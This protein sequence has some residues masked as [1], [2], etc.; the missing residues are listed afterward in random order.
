M[1][2]VEKAVMRLKKFRNRCDE[3]A[4]RRW[5]VFASFGMN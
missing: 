5:D 2:E 4:S 3:N 1:T